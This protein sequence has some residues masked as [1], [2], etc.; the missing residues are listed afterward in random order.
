MRK[1]LVWLDDHILTIFSFFLIAFIPLY[2]KV[3]VLEAIPGY[4]V[5]VRIEDFL[6]LTAFLIFLIQVFRKKATFK[7]IIF[8]PMVIY[9]TIGFL[10][11]LSAIFITKTVPWSQIHIVKIFLHWMRR[12]EYFSIFFI[13][14]NGIRRLKD[15]KILL[16]FTIPIVVLIAIYG[17]GQKYLYW[18]VY[19]TMNREFSKG[20]KLYLTEH[21]RV[22]S[23]FGGHYDLAAFLVIFLTL[24]VGLF[25]LT[26][27]KIIRW[28]SLAA[29]LLSYW[30]L[31][32][33][34][35]RTSFIAYL[36][37]LSILFFILISKKGWLWSS[38]RWL[39]FVVFSLIIMLSFGDLSERYANFLGMPAIK[40]KLKL[41]N[42]L[43]PFKSPPTNFIALNEDIQLVMD[44]TDK[45]PTTKF[46]T[47]DGNSSSTDSS[48]NQAYSNATAAGETKL[49][50][51]VYKDIPNGL[52]LVKSATQS[53]K[54]ELVPKPRTFS[55]NAYK[56]GLST[57]IRLDSL[58][59]WAI[60]A[61]KRNPLLGS[62][63]STLNKSSLGDFTEAEST[64]NDYLRSLG[65]TGLLGFISFFSIIVILIIY[66]LK[67][68]KTK[69]DPILLAFR[70]GFI[71]LTIGLLINALYIDIFEASKVAFIFWALAG[72]LLASFQQKG[73]E[74]T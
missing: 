12:I 57:A 16:I 47:L 10:S 13:F 72:I 8:W 29:Y 20:M 48:S 2:P 14:Y 43:K 1:L 49:P 69:Q 60:E 24:F 71:S 34:A 15:T 28:I 23:T 63:Y 55:E 4:I 39:G 35:S 44:E 41:N 58:W 37:S 25:A 61:F 66:T 64:D 40:D 73:Y 53:G 22:P 65:E 11:V 59:P 26:K 31:I 46:P 30:L 38:V 7:A 50:A 42:L 62:G 33:T 56:Y 3:P 54:F 68:L 19:S 6:V 9:L 17:Y 21:A 45:T 52:M 70:V 5:R 67:S 18:P 36:A 51:D 32:L 74:K 27:N